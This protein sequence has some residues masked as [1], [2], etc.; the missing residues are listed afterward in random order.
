MRHVAR[1]SLGADNRNS[2]ARYRQVGYTDPAS[3]RRLFH[4]PGR[5]DARRVPAPV[6]LSMTP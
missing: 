3:S 2:Q 5:D 1:L 4:Q 6:S